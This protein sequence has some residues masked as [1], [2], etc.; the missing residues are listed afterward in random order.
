MKINRIRV[1]FAVI[2]L[3]S[4]ISITFLA[5]SN[6]TILDH[7][8]YSQGTDRFMD[9]FN[10]IGYVQK[11]GLSK[12]YYQN[13]NACFPPLAYLFQAAALSGTDFVQYWWHLRY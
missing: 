2:L 4:A 10:H 6:R 7:L 8:V 13:Y 3:F 1:Y 5:F 11:E 12:V 9:F